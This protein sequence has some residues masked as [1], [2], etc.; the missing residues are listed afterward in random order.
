MD[1]VCRT[2]SFNLYG[3]DT[4]TSWASLLSRRFGKTGDYSAAP[5]AGGW[6]ARAGKRAG[7]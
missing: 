2:R 6:E 4:C 3:P 1:Q 5:L 7:V